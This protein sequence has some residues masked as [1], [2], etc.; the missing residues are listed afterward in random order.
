MKRLF[1]GWTLVI[2]M[3]ASACGGKAPPV[4]FCGKII[5]AEETL[6]ACNEE[7][8]TNIEAVVGLTNLENLDISGTQVVRLDALGAAFNLKMLNLNGTP[9]DSIGKLKDLR[10]LRQLRMDYTMVKDVQGIQVF[11]KMQVLSLNWSNVT[12]LT[13]IAALSN[14]DQLYIDGI[15]ARAADGFQ[16]DLTPLHGLKSLRKLGLFE[17]RVT[18]ESLAALKKV[19][20]N[21]Q[22]SGCEGKGE[23]PCR[24]SP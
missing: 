24:L 21:L 5:P 20:P 3:M 9:V 13:P 18:A 15:G 22:V 16:A 14:L 17:A 10:N 19:N 6:V 7:Q 8:Y 23:S 1:T 11:E 12:D 4:R 2:W